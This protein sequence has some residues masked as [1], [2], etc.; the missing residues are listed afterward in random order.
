MGARGVHVDHIVAVRAERLILYIKNLGHQC[1]AYHPPITAAVA[2][3]AIVPFFIVNVPL[4]CPQR[5]TLPADGWY[6][7]PEYPGIP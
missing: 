1:T 2:V 4:L 5:T 7:V 3:A 6:L